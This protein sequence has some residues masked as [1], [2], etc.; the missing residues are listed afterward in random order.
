MTISKAVAQRVARD[1]WKNGFSIFPIDRTLVKPT[2]VDFKRF[3]DRRT[4]RND[5]ES[6]RFEV[7]GEG[8]FDAGLNSRIGQVGKDKKWYFHDNVYLRQRLSKLDVGLYGLD[9]QFLDDSQRLFSYSSNLAVA[10]GVE[11]DSLYQL[12]VSEQIRSCITTV[13]PFCTS[14]LRSLYYPD[15]AGQTGAKAH[16]D[17]GLFTIH[18]G[19]L[20]GCL[21]VV[22]DVTGSNPR[23]ISPPEGY[24]VIFWGIKALW[25]TGGEKHPVW[26]QSTTT[27]GEARFAF[28]NFIHVPIT[29]YLVKDN[30]EALKDFYQTF[31]PRIESGEYIWDTA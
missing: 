14:T 7:P 3:L 24:A 19:D 2:A 28:V 30:V 8:E 13:R 18:F 27:K 11:L 9:K 12:R 10:I 5:A 26:H 22:D 6:W 4:A 25:V 29:E 17:R 15:I 31:L 16:V 23:A 1:L 20:G 21:S